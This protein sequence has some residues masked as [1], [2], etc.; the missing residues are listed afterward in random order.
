MEGKTGA[1]LERLRGLANTRPVRLVDPATL[2][3]LYRTAG[4]AGDSKLAASARQMLTEHYPD[5]PER[6][7]L[8][9]TESGA[10]SKTG[11]GSS[12]GAESP[13]SARI[14]RMP[15]PG[16]IF[17]HGGPIETTPPQN[18]S[19]GEGSPEEPSGSA[20]AEHLPRGIQAGSFSKREN[21]AYMAED[22]GEEGFDAE[23]V[24]VSV[25][26]STY[27]RVI[28]PVDTD[29]PPE[30]RQRAAEE[31]Y[32]RLKSQGVDGLMVFED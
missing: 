7:L 31:L 23:V 13:R 12:A 18:D 17:Y 11:A 3:L 15:T 4:E 9:K 10:E 22:L 19:S 1:A 28:V 14:S 27:Y 21:A 8:A 2:L 26:G 29:A 5:S 24:K 20:P 25:Q 30:A 32:I 16:Y 6:Q